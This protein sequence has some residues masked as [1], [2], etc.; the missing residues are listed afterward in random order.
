M[1][2]KRIPKWSEP[3]S[4]RTCQSVI[5]LAKELVANVRSKTL[6]L[7]KPGRKYIPVLGVLISTKSLTSNQSTK[8]FAP[9]EGFIKG[10]YQGW[11]VLKSPNKRVFESNSYCLL[12]SRSIVLGPCPN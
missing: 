6:S 1:T 2:V 10:S 3:K 7:T 5:R 11:C 9:K 8:S 4:G 12:N